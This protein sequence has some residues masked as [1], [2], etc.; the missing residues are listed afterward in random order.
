MAPITPGHAVQVAE[1]QLASFQ[2]YM[3]E[4]EG[5]APAT[6]RIYRSIFQRR[7]EGREVMN[8]LTSTRAEAC[9]DRYVKSEYVSRAGKAPPIR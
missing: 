7:R 5:M 2:T 9:W 6:A 1:A 4:G 3:V 8:T